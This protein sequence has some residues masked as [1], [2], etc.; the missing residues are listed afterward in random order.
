MNFS[1]AENHP[2]FVSL[3]DTYSDIFEN[4]LLKKSSLLAAIQGLG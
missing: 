3:Y 1:L 4:E 2:L